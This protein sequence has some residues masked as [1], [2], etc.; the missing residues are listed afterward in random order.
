MT[1]TQLPKI[2]TWEDIYRQLYPQPAPSRV[3]ESWL[4]EQVEDLLNEE[5]ELAFVRKLQS[6]RKIMK[7]GRNGV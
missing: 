1:N 2:V 5:D 6:F 3:D 4:E 7:G